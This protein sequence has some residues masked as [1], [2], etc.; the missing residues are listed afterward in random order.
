MK[1]QELTYSHTAGFQPV[2]STTQEV[3]YSRAAGF[4]PV[5]STQ[6]EGAEPDNGK[7]ITL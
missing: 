1:R 5:A 4:Q 3:T 2:A 6:Q 7:E